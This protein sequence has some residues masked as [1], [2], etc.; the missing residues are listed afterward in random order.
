MKI[1]VHDPID[2]RLACL[3]GAARVPH[4]RIGDQN[5]NTPFIRDDLIDPGVDRCGVFDVQRDDVQCNTCR[6][7]CRVQRCALFQISHAG[8]NG[9]PGLRRLHGRGN[10]KTSRRTGDQK[11]L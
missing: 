10:A 5:V 2:V 7:C 9:E 11:D 3:F 8:V 6:V 4:A 1:H